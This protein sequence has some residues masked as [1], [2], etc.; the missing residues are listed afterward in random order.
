M[1]RRAIRKAMLPSCIAALAAFSGLVW[2]APLRNGSDSRPW[3][4]PETTLNGPPAAA[5]V[6]PDGTPSVAS[7]ANGTP[8]LS[9]RMS[10]G[11]SGVEPSPHGAASAAGMVVA[12][13]PETG[14]LGMPS[15]EQMRV[16]QEHERLAESLR[17][18]PDGFI[19]I[20]RAD[21]AVGIEMKGRLQ[22]YSV[23]QVGPDGKPAF[24]CVSSRS[25]TAAVAGTPAPAGEER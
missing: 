16:I 12:R 18:T 1:I 9:P 22:S 3:P 17:S 25:D 6:A 24:R 15:P 19:E 21:G 2:L 10:L 7:D 13:D 20:H 5:A 4:P 11:A 23:V 14:E 8:A